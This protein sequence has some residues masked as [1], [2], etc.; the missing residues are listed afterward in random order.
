M[1]ALV[2][3]HNKLV[4]IILDSH[5]VSCMVMVMQNNKPTIT[6][7]QQWNGYFADRGFLNSHALHE[8]LALFLNRYNLQYNYTSIMFSHSLIEEYCAHDYVPEKKVT[9]HESHVSLSMQLAADKYGYYG[10]YASRFLIMQSIMLLHA[11]AL[12]CLQITTNTA[13]LI[14]GLYEIMPDL[15]LAWHNDTITMHKKFTD[16]VEDE[17]INKSILVEGATFIQKAERIQALGIFWAREG[18][19]GKF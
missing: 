16:S 2:P 7:Y 5:Y 6:H 13:A 3:I 11:L 10:A 4:S 1:R 18:L 17:I 12:H 19:H 9:M 15:S 14:K 8:L